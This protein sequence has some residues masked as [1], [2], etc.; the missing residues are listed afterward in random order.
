MSQVTTG[1]RRILSV[2]FVYDCFQKLV[3]AYAGRKDILERHVRVETGQRVLDLG[4]GTG[5]ALAYMPPVDY[6]GLDLNQN[7]IRQARARYGERGIFRCRDINTVKFDEEE[8]FDVALAFAL[9]HHLNDD[10]VVALFEKVGSV[11][12]LGGRLVTLD[13]CVTDSQ[14]LLA[15][16]MIRF[17][18][19]QHIRT[20]P[21]Y[22]Y[23]AESVFPHVRVHLKYDFLRFKYAHIVMECW[24]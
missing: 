12:R 2:P 13:L 22:R 17:D 1:L 5:F 11:L 21:E 8:K 20:V 7:Y 15:K 3:G 23:L 10:E 18:R 14:S 9:L 16:T 6:I 24:T 4:C 19:G